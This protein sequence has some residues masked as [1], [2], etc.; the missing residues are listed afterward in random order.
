MTGDSLCQDLQ[1][2]AG[3]FYG[4]EEAHYPETTLEVKREKLRNIFSAQKDF[5]PGGDEQIGL[6]YSAAAEDEE[7][8]SFILKCQEERRIQGNLLS[9]PHAASL[10]VP[11][12]NHVM[13]MEEQRPDFVADPSL[14]YASGWKEFLRYFLTTHKAIARQLYREKDNQT[15]KPQRRIAVPLVA[16][17]LL[18]GKAIN[19]VDVGCSANTLLTYLAE[20][21]PFEAIEDETS[22]RGKTGIVTAAARQPLTLQFGLG[23]DRQYPLAT[24]ADIEFLLSCR[25]FDEMSEEKIEQTRAIFERIRSHNVANVSFFKGD[26]LRL[27]IPVRGIDIVTVFTMLYQYPR[28]LQERILANIQKMLHPEYGVVIR[29]DYAHVQNGEVV[30]TDERKFY[31]YSAIVDGPALQNKPYEILNFRDTSC[32]RVRNGPDLERFLALAGHIR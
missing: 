10:L 5:P 16:H 1:C 26:I 14:Q 15:T 6:L 28:E 8:L 18:N 13:R 17:H 27:D 25:H 3:F 11:I 12:I 20:N 22:V 24:P 23:I 31:D 21:Q 2:D 30:P 29:Q 9:Y 19:M 4:H 32:H 7:A